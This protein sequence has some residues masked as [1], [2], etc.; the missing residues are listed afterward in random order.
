MVMSQYEIHWSSC[1]IATSQHDVM[2]ECNGH[3]HIC[4]YA[5]HINVFVTLIH[6]SKLMLHCDTQQCYMS[7]CNIHA[8]LGENM[9]QKMVMLDCNNNHYFSQCDIHWS[10]HHTATSHNGVMSH[11]NVHDNSWCIVTLINGYVDYDINLLLTIFNVLHNLFQHV[12]LWE[13]ILHVTI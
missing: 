5:T 10:S 9:T 4:H 3:Q 8:S 13:A 12:L 2:S 6:S 7:D 1:C 11:C